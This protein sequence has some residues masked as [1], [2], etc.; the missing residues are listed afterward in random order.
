[1]IVEGGKTGV[2][3][4]WGI[5]GL[6]SCEYEWELARLD[7]TTSTWCFSSRFSS[8]GTEVMVAVADQGAV[9]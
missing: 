2:S 1:M 7:S 9:L 5:E 8:V 3:R 6:R 4:F